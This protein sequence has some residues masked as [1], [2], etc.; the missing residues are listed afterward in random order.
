M[1][2]SCWMTGES[3]RNELRRKGNTSSEKCLPWVPGTERAQ[4]E[5]WLHQPVLLGDERR[6]WQQ[7]GPEHRVG[8]GR[9]A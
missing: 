9:R 4:Q 2:H 7:E 1:E 8:K 3:T 6:V 5:R